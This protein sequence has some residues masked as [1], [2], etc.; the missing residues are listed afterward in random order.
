MYAGQDMCTCDMCMH[1]MCACMCDV[2]ILHLCGSC[3][4]RVHAGKLSY[5]KQHAPINT[6]SQTCSS[7]L[8]C[9]LMSNY[10]IS[11]ECLFHFIPLY[12]LN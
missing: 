3:V 7:S 5:I 12:M 2:C 6:C 8:M 4:S 1:V 9:F 10:T 11:L